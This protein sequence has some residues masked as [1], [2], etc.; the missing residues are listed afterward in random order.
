MLCMESFVQFASFSFRSLFKRAIKME[1]MGAQ[2]RFD[3]LPWV[4]HSFPDAPAKSIAR[5]SG[6]DIHGFRQADGE[7]SWRT[8]IERLQ[9]VTLRHLTYCIHSFIN[10][11]GNLRTLDIAFCYGQTKRNTPLHILLCPLDHR[12]HNKHDHPASWCLQ[13]P[14]R[15]ECSVEAVAALEWRPTRLQTLDYQDLRKPRFLIYWIIN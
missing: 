11:K 10:P 5:W 15:C 8:N 3:D 9:N 1:E 4:S 13:P 14:I 6:P 7:D 12:H 2:K